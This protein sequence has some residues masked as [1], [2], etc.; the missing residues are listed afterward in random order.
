[1]LDYLT[2]WIALPDGLDC[3]PARPDWNEYGSL[4]L[5][6]GAPCAR[7]Y[8]VAAPAPPPVLAEW[9]VR[10]A[11]ALG[12]SA[13]FGGLGLT[14]RQLLYC[15]QPL[16]AGLVA[17][18]AV[19]FLCWLEGADAAAGAL[20]AVIAEVWP[21][22]R[23]VVTHP[24]APHAALAREALP[25]VPGADEAAAAFV[26]DGRRLRP[27]FLIRAVLD[28]PGRAIAHGHAAAIV[29]PAPSDPVLTPGDLA[30]PSPD[31]LDPFD[32]PWT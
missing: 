12:L 15:A 25:D 19:R 14:H 27:A 21:T 8:G 22:P 10:Q 32:G 26:L 17:A 6:A 1:M 5:R 24:R 31:D 29:A 9:G 20:D 30:R 2:D 7:R 28:G 13:G 23:T 11:Y 18:H 16:L 3:A 4:L